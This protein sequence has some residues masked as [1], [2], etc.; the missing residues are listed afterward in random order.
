MI[1]DLIPRKRKQGGSL[2]L[3]FLTNISDLGPAASNIDDAIDLLSSS[4]DKEDRHPEKRMKASYKKFEEE[5]YETVKR[6][7]PSLKEQFIHLMPHII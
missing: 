5:R 1:L 4:N 7:N 2:A 3:N 6:E